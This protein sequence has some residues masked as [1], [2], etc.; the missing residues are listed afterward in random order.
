MK[1]GPRFLAAVLAAASAIPGQTPRVRDTNGNSWWV[2]Y[3]DHP[4]GARLNVLSEL[5]WR[6]T[7]FA[8]AGQQLLL[9]EG[10]SYQ[11][12]PAVLVGGGYGF[13][14]TYR[15]GGFPAARAFNEHRMFEQIVLKHRAAVVDFEHRYRLEQRWLRAFQNNRPY[16]RYQ[17]RFRYQLRGAYGLGKSPW[18]LVGLDEI[19]IHFGANQG[20]SAFDQNRAFAGVGYKLNADNKVE[21]G[22][23][24]QFLVQRSGLV[25]ESNHMLRVQ[26]TS[27]SRLFQ[28]R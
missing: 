8:A 12:N 9:R 14:R 23:M 20:A 24:N 13:V 26:W 11:L 16:W 18:Y 2:Y 28:K 10:I 27:N 17:N 5:Q 1:G 25:E 22:Y 19:F 4:V 3:G 6:R 15:Y 7:N 21:V